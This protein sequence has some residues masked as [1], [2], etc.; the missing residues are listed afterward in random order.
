MSS[1]LS[2][3]RVCEYCKN[4]FVAKTT[5]TRFCSPICNGRNNK[6][7]IR[8]LKIKESDLDTLSKSNDTQTQKIEEI[9][10]RDFLTVKD[11]SLLLNISTKTLY[12]L[13]E[14]KEINSFTFHHEK[15]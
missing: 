9:K 12:R 3:N 4:T 7:I 6:M 8:N 2:V 1:N 10:G 14:R 5:R 11:A 13:I 15:H